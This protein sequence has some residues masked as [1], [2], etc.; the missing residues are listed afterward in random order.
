MP[1][2]RPP[3]DPIRRAMMQ[4]GASGAAFAES[5]AV[6]GHP[7]EAGPTGTAAEGKGG[8]GARPFVHLRVHSAYSLLEGALP[9]GKIVG[10]A[11]KDQA[12]A[13]AITD[14]NN[15]FGAL[16]FANKT[17]KDGIQPLIGC[18]LDLSFSGEPSD[19]RG[20]GHRRTGVEHNPVVLIAATEDG[21]ANLVRLVSRA[22]L[23]NPP[24]EAIRV[25]TQWLEELS[26]GLICLTG[27][28]RGPIGMALKFDHA[29]LAENRLLKLKSI[30]GDRLYVEL[31]AGRD[32]GPAR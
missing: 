23:D 7:A 5:K 15:L 1:A 18:Q 12:P 25:S 22:Y 19:A 10:L 26:A 32:V 9:I 20:G 8:S 27:G 29:D 30:F 14:T 13:V 31:E 11:L 3:R 4:S 2:D 6:S 28:P 24:G 16:E 21:Y 17:V